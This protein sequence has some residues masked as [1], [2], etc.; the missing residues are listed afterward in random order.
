MRNTANLPVL[1]IVLAVILTVGVLIS[2]VG[3][4]GTLKVL[5]LAAVAWAVGLATY[6]IQGLISVLLE[7]HELRPGRVLPRLSDPLTLA[8]A[9]LSL[10]LFGIAIFLAVGLTSEWGV[11]ALGALAGA[12]C[13]VLALLLVSYKEAFVGEE[14][15]LDDRDD[16]IPW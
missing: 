7:G 13:L 9:L 15:T 14:A 1:G 10:V 4:P 3:E 8:I 2:A 16:G 5:E 11:K 6:G 12:G